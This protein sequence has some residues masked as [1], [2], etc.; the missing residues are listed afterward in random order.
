MTAA[1]RV[2][3]L[4]RLLLGQARYP[5][6]I[7]ALCSM[8][9]CVLP[10]APDFQDPL[11]SPNY[12]PF[13]ISSSPQ[14]GSIVTGMP[15]TTTTFRVTVSDPNVG[16]DLHVRW[17]ADYP[18]LSAA[19]TRLLVSDSV[20]SHSADGQPI[21]QDVSVAIGCRQSVLSPQLT[22]H[23]VTVLVADRAY[24]ALP[25]DG[26]DNLTKLVDDAG[27]IVSASWILTVEC[28]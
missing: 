26:S 18:P 1:A 10:I 6:T 7:L 21:V 16:D 28:R 15:T 3:R 20:I 23:Q 17:L 11:S 13:I 22:Q 4:A 8:S 2:L 14:A 27:F 24:E 12:S 25:L 9:A 19:N 5:T